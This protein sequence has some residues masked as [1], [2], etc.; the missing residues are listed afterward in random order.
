M[1][2]LRKEKKTVEQNLWQIDI[3]LTEPKKK[4]IEF[5][6]KTF[7][8][9]QIVSRKKSILINFWQNFFLFLPFLKRNL[10][11]FL[12]LC[13]VAYFTWFVDFYS[14]TFV[15]M[16]VGQLIHKNRNL[17]TYC[18]LTK[19]MIGLKR[20]Q[21]NTLLIICP[22]GQMAIGEMSI[23]K[24]SLV[25][26]AIAKCLLAKYPITGLNRFQENFYWSNVPWL[27]VH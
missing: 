6:Q 2:E 24:M 5:A 20:F 21:P 25:K 8:S 16:T 14:K 13:K 9:F 19:W 1:S 10:I 26:C 23:G 7:F 12:S 15:L 18:L 22:I 3:F 4:K 17:L 27:N 11:F